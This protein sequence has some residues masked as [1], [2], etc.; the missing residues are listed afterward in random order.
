MTTSGFVTVRRVTISHYNVLHIFHSLSAAN[1]RLN[2]YFPYS[3]VNQAWDAKEYS[4]DTEK[5]LQN[6]TDGRSEGEIWVEAAGIMDECF[7]E[8]GDGKER[9]ERSI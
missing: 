3:T 6:L 1:A 5:G 4:V 8:G 2:I 9:D 7:D